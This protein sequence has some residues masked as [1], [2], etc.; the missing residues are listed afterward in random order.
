MQTLFTFFVF[1]LFSFSAI[2]QEA[3]VYHVVPS[4]YTSTPGNGAFTS[5]LST[6]PRTYQLL[7]HESL[8]APILT[9]QIYAVSWRLP[10]SATANWPASDITITNYDF[11]LG[12]SVDPANMSLTDFS[13]NFVGPKKQV[14]AGSLTIL[15]NTYTFGNTP[16]NW[17]PEMTFFLDS[18][19]VYN[20]G[21]LLIELRQTGFTGTS[22]S[23]DA[24]TTSTTGYGTLFR[25]C[26]AS[27]YTANSGSQ[28][29][30]SI[31]RITAD[32]PVPVELTSFAATVN[33]RDVILQ[34]TTATEL[35]NSGFQVERRTSE[36]DY[37]AIGF[38]AGSG[39]TT[40]QRSYLFND[41]K[42]SEGEYIYR[43]KQID[44]NG[45]FN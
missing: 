4:D 11:Y 3:I 22:R 41:A 2:A 30:F 36:T 31:V 18:I 29:N 17:G 34:W 40:E 25:S 42:L 10:T 5:Q 1:L 35:N 14:R 37:D 23:V 39:T 16:N 19:Y 38:V 9:K 15:A 43:L 27:G 28:G 44:F 45:Q 12:Q 26:W 8:L 13:A 20:G 33:G 7:M 6:T 24:L 21:N 32:D